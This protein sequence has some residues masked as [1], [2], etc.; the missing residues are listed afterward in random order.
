MKKRKRYFG[1]I[2]LEINDIASDDHK[3]PGT[4]KQHEVTVFIPIYVR[5]TLFEDLT[6]KQACHLYEYKDVK[7]KSSILFVNLTT[8]P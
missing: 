7:N 2:D 4:S 5:H 8:S 6:L 3:E 1:H